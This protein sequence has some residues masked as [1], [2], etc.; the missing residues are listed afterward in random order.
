MYLCGVYCNTA[1]GV[2]TVSVDI[3][4]SQ[5]LCPSRH[6]L[7]LCSFAAMYTTT[8]TDAPLSA[9]TMYTAASTP[10]S[11]RGPSGHGVTSLRAVPGHRCLL[12]A[13][14]TGDIHLIQLGASTVQGSG[15]TQLAAVFSPSV[16]QTLPAPLYLQAPASNNAAAGE[17]DAV[18]QV[19]LAI[20]RMF[21]A[22]QPTAVLATCAGD[23]HL[24]GLIR[25]HSN[26]LELYYYHDGR[27]VNFLNVSIKTPQDLETHSEGVKSA[28]FKASAPAQ[29]EHATDIAVSAVH[30]IVTDRTY[31]IS[32]VGKVPPQASE[33]STMTLEEAV[34]A[35]VYLFSGSVTLPDTPAATVQS[36]LRLT[37]SGAALD[38]TPYLATLRQR[39]LLDESPT[40]SS[41]AAL[42]LIEGSR[43][44][45]RSNTQSALARALAVHN[46]VSFAGRHCAVVTAECIHVVDLFKVS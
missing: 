25:K 7:S 4:K 12:V 19:Q 29:Y 27:L 43:A 44:Q 20:E 22:H 36:V 5:A 15:G 30:V 2:G 13:L 26:I 21:N 31:L 39:V 8:V 3:T 45:S 17:S 9:Y 14:E 16:V 24:S 40:L 28:Y 42:A 41:S 6:S 18:A 34:K 23:D 38:T 1:S 10:H 46:S 33:G 32:V 11:I 35:P 37:Q